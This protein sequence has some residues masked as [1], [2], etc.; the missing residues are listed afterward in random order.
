VTPLAVPRITLDI[1]AIVAERARRGPAVH[2]SRIVH[3][4]TAE[5]CT[6]VR[7][8]V[9][10]GLPRAEA[11]K[12]A[13]MPSHCPDKSANLHSSANA[14]DMLNVSERTVKAAKQVRERGAS[15]LISAVERGEVSVSAA[16]DVAAALTLQ[17]RVAAARTLLEENERAPGGNGM[18]QV[19]GFAILIADARVQALPVGPVLDQIGHHPY[20]QTDRERRDRSAA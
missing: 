4:L 12:L 1:A 13:N 11:A 18:P 7:L 3:Q 8:I 6:A 20:R 14:A 10:D 17:P 16:A 5:M 2:Q 19:P 15:E 9:Q